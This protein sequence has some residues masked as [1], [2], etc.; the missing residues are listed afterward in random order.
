MRSHLRTLVGITLSVLLLLWVLRDVSPA[1]VGRELA[2]ANLWVLAAAVGITIVGFAIRAFRWGILLRP[3]QRDLG[4]RPRY[5]AV[6]IGFAAN[7]VLPARVGE[8]ARALTLARLT[9]V[10]AAGSL[11]TL[12]VERILDG[13]VLVA[14]LFG[15]M[16]VPT[17]PA[18][19]L[20][21]GVDPRAAAQVVGIAMVLAA[22][23]LL[24]LVVAPARAVRVV[25][26]VAKRILPE[27]IGGAV[28]GALESFLGGLAVLRDSRL[29]V[30]SV[31]LALGQWV[32]TALSYLLA[33]RAFGINEV[34]FM[35]AVFLQSLI[36]L[37]VAVPSSPGF[38]GPFEAAARVGLA[39][40]GVEAGKAVSFAVGYHIAGF[41]PVT[42]I[43]MY[44]VWRLDLTWRDVR[45]SEEVVE[46][47][48]E[49]EPVGSPQAGEA[50]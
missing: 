36:S 11:A 9:P 46:E 30:A 43:G 24:L 32:V 14:L 34:P 25:E 21:A 4:F 38:F 6:T 47:R 42:L 49:A 37:A 28:V 44:Y 13:L 16:A 45:R 20:V 17:F 3:I 39:L 33:M 8:F 23:G 26:A 50:G 12:V 29:L 7:N 5:A 2:Q 48:I 19:G 31:A 15:A 27:R 1:E 10:T 41:I 18:M 40:W 35:G 22:A